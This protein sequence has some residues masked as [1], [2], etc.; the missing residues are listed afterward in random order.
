M[1]A[2]RRNLTGPGRLLLPG[3]CL[4]WLVPTLTFARGDRY[5][6]LYDRAFELIEAGSYQASI[7]LLRK[8]AELQ[9]YNERA[10]YTLALALLYQEKP[11][12]AAPYKAS[13]KE[14]I[15]H[16]R[17]TVEVWK[18]VSP[19]GEELG[20]RYFYLGLALWYYGEPVQALEAFRASYR[21]DFER[22]D[23]VYNQFALLE[24]LGKYQEAAE[25]WV[26]YKQLQDTNTIDD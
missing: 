17:A 25:V 4:F 11:V 15:Q 20:L 1:S 23:A 12:P 13:L 19:R 3:F 2:A 26:L 14:A 5:R 9:P 21:A 22:L 24:E 8:M 6:Q 10:H 7:P 18:R 16:F